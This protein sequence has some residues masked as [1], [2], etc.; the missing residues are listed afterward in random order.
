MIKPEDRM[1]LC[2][3]SDALADAARLHQS[4]KAVADDPMLRRELAEEADR[5]GQL[6]QEVRDG[7]DD[8]QAGTMLRLMAELRL[9]VDYWFGDDDRAARDASRDSLGDL[10]ALIDDHLRNPELSEDVR[11]VFTGARDA[12]VGPDER[13]SAAAGLKTMMR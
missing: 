10:L 12:L 11:A 8:G 5:L 2:A 3:L 13:M 4:A 7:C 6:S 1:A 9:V